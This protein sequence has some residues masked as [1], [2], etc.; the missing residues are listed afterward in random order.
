MRD[1]EEGERRDSG[2]RRGF[3]GP[4]M[5]KPVKVGEEHDVTVEAVGSRGDGIAKVNNFVVFVPGVQAGQAVK[6]RI[7]SVR[8]RFATVEIV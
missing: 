4:V 5:D 1:F 6:V 2:G 7:T 3:D 8:E